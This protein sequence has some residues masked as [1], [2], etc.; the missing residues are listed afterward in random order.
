MA[1]C[2]PTML[3]YTLKNDYAAADKAGSG[4]HK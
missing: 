3:S 1:Y 4:G 2:Y